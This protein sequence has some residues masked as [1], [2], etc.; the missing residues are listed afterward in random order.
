M[1]RRMALLFILGLSVVVHPISGDEL[2]IASAARCANLPDFAQATVPSGYREIRIWLMSALSDPDHMLRLAIRDGAVEG[3]W[4]VWWG[5]SDKK[6]QRS[7]RRLVDREYHCEGMRRCGDVE[8]CQ[9]T[10][11]RTP[12]WQALYAVLE[13]NGVWTLPDSSTLPPVD[14]TVF[15]G[16]SMVVETHSVTGRRSYEYDNPEEYPWPEAAKAKVIMDS[17]YEAYRMNAR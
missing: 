3:T 10:F 2:L 1:Q 9:A 8:V 12:A 14:F 5:D 17:V 15:D 7:V 11:T 13:A 6:Y 4:Y 16:K